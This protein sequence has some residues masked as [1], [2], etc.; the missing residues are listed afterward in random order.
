MKHLGLSADRFE[1]TF[2]SGLS[3]HRVWN[4]DLIK[5]IYNNVTILENEKEIPELG[6]NEIKTCEKYIHI[7]DKLWAEW[8]SDEDKIVMQFLADIIKSMNVKGYINIDDLYNLSEKEIINKIL[9]CDDKY[10]KE[11]FINFQNATSIYTSNVPVQDKYC[12]SVKSKRR[13]IIPLVKTGNGTIRINEIS[14]QAQNDINEYF[15]IKHSKYI[16][17]NFDFKPYES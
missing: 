4:L 10:I 2:S 3:F 7:I 13:Y 15:S 16:G 11:S 5:E 12:I 14:S 6:F 1:Y 17:L 9:N 8:I